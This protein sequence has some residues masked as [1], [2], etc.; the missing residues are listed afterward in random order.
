MGLVSEHSR[1]SHVHFWGKFAHLDVQRLRILSIDN[2][3]ADALQAEKA[4][5][6]SRDLH[7]LLCMRLQT[8]AGVASHSAV[9]CVLWARFVPPK[10]VRSPS[11]LVILHQSK[12]ICK[13]GSITRVFLTY[14]ANASQHTDTIRC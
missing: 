2:N 12:G 3:T 4:L 9:T 13:D 10:C 6:F 7:P 8:V 14:S 11:D 5:A 1:L